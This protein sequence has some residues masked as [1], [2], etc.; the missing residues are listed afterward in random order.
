[1][2]KNIKVNGYILIYKPEHPFAK[3]SGYIFEHRLVMEKFLGRYLLPEER[4][5]HDNDVK[6]DNRIENLSLFLNTKRHLKYH[7][8]LRKFE[9]VIKDKLSSGKM[10]Q[11][12]HIGTC[13]KNWT[14]V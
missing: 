3:K 7:L 12:A 11:E 14:Y 6:D 1:M 8:G 2:R 5:H 10:C 9:K 13:W 4:V